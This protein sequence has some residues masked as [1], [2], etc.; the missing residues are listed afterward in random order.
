MNLKENYDEVD[1]DDD[2]TLTAYNLS[3]VEVF[4]LLSSFSLIND[5]SDRFLL[6][7]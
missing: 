1:V 7:C 6:L 3:K 4:S 2:A 5:I